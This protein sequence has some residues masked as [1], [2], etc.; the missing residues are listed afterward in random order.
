MSKSY[1]GYVNYLDLNANKVFIDTSSTLV[2]KDIGKEMDEYLKSIF[3]LSNP[4]LKIVSVSFNCIVFLGQSTYYMIIKYLDLLF[5]EQT[6]TISRN[7]KTS[8]DTDVF[9]NIF[10]NKIVGVATFVMS[11]DVYSSW[12]FFGIMLDGR[13]TIF[14]YKND[15]SKNTVTKTLTFVD[16]MTI[17]FNTVIKYHSMSLIM[18]SGLRDYQFNY[19]YM[20]MLKRYYYV[21]SVTLTNDTKQI[22]LVED[23]LMSW[24]ELIRSQTA[25]V[26]RNENTYNADLYDD[27]YPDLVSKDYHITEYKNDLFYTDILNR[28]SNTYATSFPI[29][30]V[31][32]G[33]SSYVGGPQ[34]GYDQSSLELNYFP[35]E[36]LG[37]GN[38]T[39]YG[40][41]PVEMNWYFTN[42]GMLDIKNI[43]RDVGEYIVSLRY[44]PFDATRFM[45]TW[46]TG[47]DILIGG[48]TCKDQTDTNI[49]GLKLQR[50]GEPLTIAT[51]KFTRQFNDFRD[52]S[53]YTKYTVYLPYLGFI[54]LDTNEIVGKTIRI[55]YAVDFLD[56]T[57]QAYIMLYSPQLD[58]DVRL[59]H[60]TDR[61]PISIE[62]PLNSTNASERL[63][64]LLLGAIQVGGGAI[65][66]ASGNAVGGV[67]SAKGAV[68]S[69]LS[70]LRVRFN[71]GNIH[72]GLQATYSPTSVFVIRESVEW[73]DVTNIP[74]LYGRPLEESKTLSTLS[75]YTEIGQIHFNPSSNDIYDD[76]I[77]EIEN[78]LR[79]GVIL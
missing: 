8:F 7:T 32:G 18:K 41:S 27:R 14:M 24:D 42:G 69:F 25:F 47:Q 59:I 15:S 49:K 35:Y 3:T 72:G 34:N 74:V 21:T 64:S 54:D 40:I 48:K 53:P 43:F 46:A 50:M 76:E 5:Q 12:Q 6:E 2:I 70:A 63:N 26:T 37:Q 45:R 55:K 4:C 44:Y 22:D 13:N 19:V 66:S 36:P 9:T 58:K 52:Y 29:M 33:S 62:V 16:S 79:T 56:G 1:S 57:V 38:I 31:S 30:V 51:I 73:A 71:R 10:H 39:I 77:T 11:D 20:P 68:G 17:D 60:V 61:K 28:F 78:L 23:V 75:G 67:K 65:S